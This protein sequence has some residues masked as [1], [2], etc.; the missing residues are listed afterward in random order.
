[1]RFYQEYN[2]FIWEFNGIKDYF[3]AVLARLIGLV[4]GLGILALIFYVL[5]VI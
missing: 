5:A 2:G 1:M 3:K 4:I